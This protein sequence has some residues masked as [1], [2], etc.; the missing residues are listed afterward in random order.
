MKLRITFTIDDLEADELGYDFK[1]PDSLKRTYQK[2]VLQDLTGNY[3]M[4][5]LNV[6]SVEILSE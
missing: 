1:N 6:E 3:N 4:I 2:E 5:D